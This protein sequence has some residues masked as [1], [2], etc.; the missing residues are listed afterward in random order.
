[1]RR[2]PLP[3]HIARANAKHSAVRF[4]VEQVFVGQKHRMG[5]FIRTTGIARPRNKI[6]ITNLA[7]NFQRLE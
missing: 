3:T 7:Y 4:A 1:M 6:G 2:R 5:L